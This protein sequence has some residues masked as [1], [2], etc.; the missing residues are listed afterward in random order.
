M[1]AADKLSRMRDVA[2]MIQEDARADAERWD[3][4][5]FSGHNIGTQLGEIRAQISA[6]G[7]LIEHLIDDVRVTS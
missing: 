5:E 2:Q 6:L 4:T 7:R 1:I 3:G